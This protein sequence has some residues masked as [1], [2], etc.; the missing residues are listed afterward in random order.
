MRKILFVLSLSLI[1][2]ACQ[3]ASNVVVDS[4]PPVNAKLTYFDR[5]SVNI[6]QY[7]NNSSLKLTLSDSFQ[8]ELSST[9]DF[10]YLDV[11]V[12]NDSGVVLNEATFTGRSGDVVSGTITAT[13]AT[14]YVGDVTYLFTPY[15]TNGA[16][17]DYATKVVRL[18]N[19]K[20]I[21]AVIDSV[22]MPDSLQLPQTGN[23]VFNI[24]A[25]VTDAAGL[26][27]VSKVYFDVVKPDG[28]PSTGNPFMMYDD[29]GAAG[30][31]AGDDDQ[32]ANDGI[33]TLY[34]QLPAGTAIGI[35]VFTFHAVDR[36]G[37]ASTPVSHKIK[38][39]Q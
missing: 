24:Y 28:N 5:D 15:N 11:K 9:E 2:A 33:Y 34:V 32:V 10:S 26:G 3:K 6:A 36:S 37:V 21:G 31:S 14:V 20:D 18:F 25:Y 39:Y 4:T 17:G 30:L 27:D 7:L 12:Q 22:S 16:P 35:Y 19:V 8:V 23:V 38:V 1:V 13:F 29:G